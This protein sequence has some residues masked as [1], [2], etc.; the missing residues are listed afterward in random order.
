MGFFEEYTDEGG[1]L[2]WLEKDEKE[3]LIKSGMAFTP[4]RIFSSDGGE[5]GEK[6]VI[7]ARL[8]DDPDEPRAFSFGKGKEGETSRDRLLKAL[9]AFLD[10][11]SEKEEGEREEAPR[12]RLKRIKQFVVVE[13]ADEE[14][15]V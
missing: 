15:V 5:Y 10:R 3:V 11:E 1:G 8:P 9:A 14:A 2:N 12:L 7:I 13:N 6:F 4:E